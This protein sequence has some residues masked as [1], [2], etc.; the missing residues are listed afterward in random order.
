MKNFFLIVFLVGVF[1]LALFGFG[2]LSSYMIDIN[3]DAWPFGLGLILPYIVLTI[4]ELFIKSRKQRNKSENY[5]KKEKDIV[6]NGIKI[7]FDLIDS[8][9]EIDERVVRNENEI[10]EIADVFLP[11]SE[12][13]ELLFH[14][15]KNY[16]TVIKFC[17]KIDKVKYH[18]KI[19]LP[20][21]KETINTIFKLQKTTI[22]L[23]DGN[24]PK[25]A[26]I[27]FGFIENY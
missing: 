5:S 7:K 6:K 4:Y 26:L 1:F 22:L 14:Q 10:R 16:I 18:K 13:N 9:V 21:N 3:I 8:I 20:F 2:K 19:L 17:Y 24:N 15:N 12:I 27:D 11:I 23:Y 25:E